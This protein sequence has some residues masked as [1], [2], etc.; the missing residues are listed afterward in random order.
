ML[1]PAIAAN[2]IKKNIK[3]QLFRVE[4]KDKSKLFVAG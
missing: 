2:S 3:L 1:E 4:N